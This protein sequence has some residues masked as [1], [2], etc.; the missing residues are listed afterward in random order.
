MATERAASPVR[1]IALTKRGAENAA[2]LV[3]AL[4]GATLY[5]PD[6]LA[7]GHPSAAAYLSTT[8]DLINELWKESRAFVLFM[9]AGIAVRAIAPLLKSKYEDP[10]VIV[11]DPAGGYAV[12]LLSGH[13]GGANELALEIAEILGGRA[14]I[15]TA[16]DSEGKPAI[17]MWAAKAGLI[18]QNPKAAAKINGAFVNAIPVALVVDPE[19]PIPPFPDEIL[20][21]L[22]LITRDPA[23]LDGFGGPAIRVTHRVLKDKGA[24]VLHPRV[25]FL[26]V[27][28]RK[29]ADPARTSGAVLEALEKA[30]Y[31]Q[32]SIARVA[33][34]D[35]KAD[36]P[37]VKKLAETLGCELSVFTADFLGKIDVPTPSEKVRSK[38][39][40][41]AVAE[42]S[43]LAA[44]RGGKLLV[45]KIKG[46]DWTMAVALGEGG[47]Q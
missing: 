24:Y 41:P 46:E 44:S 31:S 5:L 1:V 10:A 25:L 42:A 23:D 27:G 26:G 15:T 22:A 38:V 34:I 13:L 11:L 20:P 18:P 32:L 47:K 6:G 45:E 28:T 37:A 29:G 40:T 7:S 39:G 17:E 33:T 2:R 12:P 8:P 9:A 35:L 4:E 21:H 19:L 30:G 3:R 16:T 14:V 43:A 36:E